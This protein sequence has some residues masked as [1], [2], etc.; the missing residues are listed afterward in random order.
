VKE[1]SCTIFKL[2]QSIWRIM[3]LLIYKEILAWSAW[4]ATPKIFV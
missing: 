2:E 3:A 4:I 1:N